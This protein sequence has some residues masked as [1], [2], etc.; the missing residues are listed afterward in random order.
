M[1]GKG[2]NFL[3]MM[4]SDFYGQPQEGIQSSTFPVWPGRQSSGGRSRDT[5]LSVEAVDVLRFFTKLKMKLMP[6]IFS[7]AC[8][9]AR[10]GVPVMRVMM[11]EFFE[12]PSCEHLDTQ[13]ML[14]DAL[15]AA[16]IFNPEG[17]AACYLPRGIWTSF[18]PGRKIEGGCW[19]KERHDYMS[20]P[21]MVRPGALIATGVS[22]E[23]PEYDYAD[24]VTVQAFELPRMR[25]WCTRPARRA[26]STSF[27]QRL[28]DS[29]FAIRSAAVR[30]LR[31]KARSCSR[32]TP[33]HLLGLGKSL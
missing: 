13:Y 17:T 24:G 16:P 14:G 19:R 9:A 7:T 27:A 21:L 30:G 4:P 25:E 33:C 12:D 8:E 28:H 5:G 29:S 26:E 22:D 18:L 3:G 32:K 20:V 2:Q 6:Y 10:T 11:L 23:R 31:G 15:L 1:G